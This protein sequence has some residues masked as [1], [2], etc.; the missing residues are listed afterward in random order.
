MKKSS[1][2]ILKPITAA[3]LAGSL[4][5]SVNSYAIDFAGSSSAVGAIAPVMVVDQVTPELLLNVHADASQNDIT[6]FSAALKIKVNEFASRG[7]LDDLPLNLNLMVKSGASPAQQGNALDAYRAVL[8]ENGITKIKTSLFSGVTINNENKGSFTNYFAKTGSKNIIIKNS[9]IQT[10]TPFAALEG[11]S[12]KQ[13]NWL[14]NKISDQAWD[15]MP[16]LTAQEPM[17]SG[18][19]S[20]AVHFTSHLSSDSDMGSQTLTMTL[21]PAAG[22]KLTS[23]NMSKLYQQ[24]GNNLQ[25]LQNLTSFNFDSTTLETMNSDV[26][27][28]FVQKLNANTSLKNVTIGDNIKFD[29]QTD[30]ENL[31]TGISSH[32]GGMFSPSVTLGKNALDFGK[33]VKEGSFGTF[34]STLQKNLKPTDGMPANV[35]FDFSSLSKMSN[36]MTAKEKQDLASGFKTVGIM[37]ATGLMSGQISNVPDSLYSDIAKIKFSV[38][39]DDSYTV[40]SDVPMTT[41]SQEKANAVNAG[42]SMTDGPWDSS[43]TGLGIEFE[44]QHQQIGTILEKG[45]KSVGEGAVIMSPTP[46]ST[47]LQGQKIAK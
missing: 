37:M 2:F 7:M 22:Q 36:N 10:G 9:D 34:M 14:D 12:L 18:S 24:L 38:G 6:Q 47:E 4:G 46:V 33:M 43:K 5:V 17:F 28:E 42:V 21:D 13:V 25:K 3:I 11:N 35:T 31:I 32:T 29:S 26:A 16:P 23:Q 20:Q 19:L 44:T 8:A 41:I 27:S 45:Q 30:V 1:H 40:G 39:G 15:E